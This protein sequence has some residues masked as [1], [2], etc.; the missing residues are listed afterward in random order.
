MDIGKL[1]LG[2]LG[3]QMEKLPYPRSS[4]CLLSLV[5]QGGRISHTAN[6]EVY[7]S[8]ACLLYTVEQEGGV[9]PYT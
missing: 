2:S 9:T 3:S 5:E 1:A 8:A 6:R 4:E 7:E